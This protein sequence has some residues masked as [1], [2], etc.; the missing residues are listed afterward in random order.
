[1]M[2]LTD[3]LQPKKKYK[4]CVIDNIVL[5]MLAIMAIMISYLPNDQI[6]I[7]FVLHVKLW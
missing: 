5:Y 6:N 4:F 7:Q 1:M 2:F 3:L